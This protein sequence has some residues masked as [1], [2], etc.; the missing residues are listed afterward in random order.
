MLVFL[1]LQLLLEV[2]WTVGIEDV[3]KLTVGGNS[4]T[5]TPGGLQGML[6]LCW[7]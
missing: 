2:V 5:T 4:V 1:L 3:F 6:L 7:Y